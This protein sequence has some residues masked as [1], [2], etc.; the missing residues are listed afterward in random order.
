MDPLN[1]NRKFMIGVDACFEIYRKV[2][3]GRTTYHRWYDDQ[4]L[5]PKNI[6]SEWIDKI[7][8]CHPQLDDARNYL[9]LLDKKTSIS[10]N[11]TDTGIKHYGLLQ[12]RQPDNYKVL[13]EEYDNFIADPTI[14]YYYTVS[15]A[16]KPIYYS[17]ET[18]KRVKK[19]SINI[20]NTIPLLTNDTIKALE[21]RE[22]IDITIPKI[23][24]QVD[25]L[26]IKLEEY[27][28]ECDINYIKDAQII[29]D[30]HKEMSEKIKK[31]SKINSDK[32][33]KHIFEKIRP[34]PSPTPPTQQSMDKTEAEKIL[35]SLNIES[36]LDWK[37]WLGKHHT[38]KGG[39]SILTR[40]VILAGKIIYE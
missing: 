38:D 29:V 40:E 36:K 23:K 34:P 31:Q 15:V 21:Y 26:K 10:N 2:H 35:K 39:S 33:L 13:V 7:V 18:K 22:L 8:D 28:K 27:E 14:N 11:L 17:K 12:I 37:K 9:K 3:N 25:N 19:T 4:Q 5:N 20:L 24:Q 30:S 16:G 32:L 1:L 6:P